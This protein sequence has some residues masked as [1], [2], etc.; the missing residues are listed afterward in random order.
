MVG[1]TIERKIDQ[2]FLII[3][4]ILTVD[5]CHCSSIAAAFATVTVVV[6]ALLLLFHVIFVP[7]PANLFDQTI[8]TNVNRQ[9]LV[10]F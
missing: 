9:I 1:V 10:N 6:F 2:N 5:V 7:Y 4:L 8:C 3:M